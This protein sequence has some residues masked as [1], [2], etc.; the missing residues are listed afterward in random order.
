MCENTGRQKRLRQKCECFEV[1]V[2]LHVEIALSALMDTELEV[3]ADHGAAS[4]AQL[5]GVIASR[6]GEAPSIWRVV[7]VHPL[8]TMTHQQMQS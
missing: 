5:R 7:G 8:V 6:P 2:A 3:L 4:G 1:E